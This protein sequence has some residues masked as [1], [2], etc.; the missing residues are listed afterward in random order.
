MN[1]QIPLEVIPRDLRQL[2]QMTSNIYESIIVIGKRANQLAAA[3]KEELH[4][5]LSEF[6][7]TTDNLEEVFENREQIEI[8][9]YYERLPKSTIVATEEMTNGEIYFRNPT[10]EALAAAEEENK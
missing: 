9:T 4:S 1:K 6:A 7:P 5:K 8:S 3:Q 2:E 10:L